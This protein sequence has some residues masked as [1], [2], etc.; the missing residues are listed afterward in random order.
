MLAF[1]PSFLE[2][3][4]HSFRHAVEQ[5]RAEGISLLHAS[6]DVEYSACDVR[7]YFASLIS[8]ELL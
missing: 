6:F 7:P 4:E 2:W 8:I 1:L 3:S 5:Q